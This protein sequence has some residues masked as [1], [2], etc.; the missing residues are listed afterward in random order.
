ML[1][2]IDSFENTKLEDFTLNFGN[3][4]YGKHGIWQTWHMANRTWLIGHD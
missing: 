2:R 3:G 1:Q 4:N